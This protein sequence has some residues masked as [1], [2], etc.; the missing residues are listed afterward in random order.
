MSF[1]QL[2][3]LN[4]QCIEIKFSTSLCDLINLYKD[5]VPWFL[6]SNIFQ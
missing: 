3:I 5:L 4:Y 1:F 6:E 2:I